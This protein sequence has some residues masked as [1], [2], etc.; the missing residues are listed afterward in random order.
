[1]GH[2]DLSRLPPGTSKYEDGVRRREGGPVEKYAPLRCPPGLPEPSTFLADLEK[3]TQSFLSQQRASLSLS[4]QYE[5]E[6]AGKNSSV[7]KN[8]PGHSRHIQ[9][10]GTGPG[11]SQVAPLGLGPDT[12]L[13]YDEFLQQHRRPVSKLDLEEKRKREAR[14]KGTGCYQTH[15]VFNSPFA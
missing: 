3:S 5:L 10:L 8:L 4:S 6:G 9:G 7:L 13:I 2:Y 12:M 11:V 1:M 14:E 15:S